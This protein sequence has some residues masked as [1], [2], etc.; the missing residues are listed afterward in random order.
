MSRVLLALFLFITSYSWS[1]VLVIN[2]LDADTPSVYTKEFIELKSQ[3]PN[4]STDGYILVFF[5]G[6]TSGDDRSYFVYDL[7]G[8]STDINGLLVVGSSNVSPFPQALMSQNVIQNGADAVGIYQAS[9]NDFPE[10]TLATQT[11]LID[12][13]VYGTNDD[14]DAGLLTKLGQTNQ[15]NDNGTNANPKSIQRFVDSSNNVTFT[16]TTPTPRRENDGSGIDINPVAISV[17]QVQYDEGATFDITFTSETN[18]T[19]NLNFNI[20]LNNYG[21]NT[22]D[23]TGNTSLTILSGQNTTTTTITLIDD[24]ADEGDEVL[25]IRFID[26][27]E[28]IVASNGAVEI[29]VVDNDFTMAEWG[30]P[31]NP[32]Y[33]VV[34]STQP[35]AYYDSLD[36]LA[37]VALRQAMQ[38]IIADPTTVRAQTY[39][40]VIDIL[41]VADQNPENSNQVWL[42]YL[43]EGRPKLDFQTSSLNTGKW[44][45]EHTFPRSRGGFYSIEEDEIADGIDVFWTTK[46]DSLRHGNSDAHALRA[47]DGPENSTR[48]NQFYGQYNGPAGTLGK[49]K[50]D[51]ARSVFYM[52]VRYNGLEIVNGYPE[53]SVGDFGDLET[54]LDWH[55]ND[56]PDD[57]EMNRNN[58]VYNWQFNR[59]P[60]ID[61]PDMIEYIWGDSI[62]L[63]WDQS[64]SIDD[65]TELNAAIYPNPTTGR[66]Y[67][68]GLDT[69]ANIEVFSVDGKLL[70]T[71]RS[72]EDYIDLDLASG[73]YHIKL[74]SDN[75]SLVK[76][77]IVN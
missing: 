62:G 54:L 10:E 69:M 31:I 40:D 66:V 8:F 50:G 70:K 65:N 33:G 64:L 59:N 3:T 72:V 44:N 18:V 34:A 9:I 53:G 61:Q 75:R 35:N 12:A 2:E 46:A 29:R 19:S 56:P 4:F 67:I 41:K 42:V 32:T 5:N 14:D 36:G 16:A 11:N 49:F 13:M 47:A 17:M 60:F 68:S 25:K 52:A 63:V 27:V 20:S 23:F 38:D 74:V 26:L 77:I 45:R 24:T 30:T 22:S 21:F 73:L 15:Y 71:Y 48:N 58:I 57:F 7:N 43:E 28:P 76:K 39:T 1:Q 51:V 6:S 37:D 55:R